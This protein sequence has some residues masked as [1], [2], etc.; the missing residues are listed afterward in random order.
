MITIPLRWIKEIDQ[1]FNKEGKDE[2]NLTSRGGNV[3][4]IKKKPIPDEL[5]GLGA[6]FVL[7]FEYNVGD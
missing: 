5:D 2:L 6:Q 4:N 3:L 1:A 7:D